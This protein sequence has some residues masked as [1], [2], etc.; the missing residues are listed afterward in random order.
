MEWSLI[1]SV[2]W[3]VC[4]GV[5][6]VA[7]SA[8]VGYVCAMLGSIRNS[9]DSI[10]NT[11]KSTEHLIDKEVTTLLW[12]VGQTVKE[13][14]KGLPEL[15]QNVN[16]ITAS[17]Q[18]ISQADIQPTVHSIREMTK[19]VSQNLEK[20]DQLV[21]GVANFS[22]HTVERAGYYRDQ[23]SIPINDVIGVWSG[24]KAGWEVFSRSRKPKES[25]SKHN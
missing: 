3:K 4:F 6:L 23:L 22:Q 5:L 20:L 7:L 25:E 10:Q 14:N 2:F 1:A 18:E 9:L 13:V 21:D 17:L 8:L 19:T 12:D 11:L 24:L 16:G 15:L